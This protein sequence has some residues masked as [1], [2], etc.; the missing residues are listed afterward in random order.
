M[1]VWE[2][3]TASGPID[4]V[5][6]LPGSKSQTARALYLAAVSDAPTTIRGA[7]DAR[8]TRLFLGALEQM[9]AS[10]DTQGGALRVTPMGERPRPA[11]IDCGLAGTVMRFLPPLAA[12][13][14]GTTRFDGDA[15]ARARP[16]APLLGALEGMGARV[17]HEGAPGR[18]PF[19]IRG[20]LRTPL[21]AQ[22]AVDASA[23]SQFLSALLLVAPLIG[24]P[25]FVSAPGRVV[26]MPHV[27]MTV[28]ALARAGIDIEE[29]DEAGPVRTWHVFPGRP[30]PGDTDI[31][32]DLSNAGPFLAAAMVTGGRVRVPGWPRTTSQPGDAWRAILGH[33]GA[34][35]E[36][37]DDGLTVEGPGAGN[38]PGIDAD[39]SAVGE[40]T[41]ALAAI[42][43][44]A[45]SPSRL[46]GIAHLRGHETDRVAALAT[47]LNRLGGDAQDGGDC[48]AIAPAPLRPGTVETYE[49][50]RMAAFGAVLGLTTAGV[51]VRDI[52][53]TSKTLPGFARMW[54][55]A[56]AG[57]RE[58]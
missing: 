23:S 40:L 4:A 12:L 27:E 32:P 10:F 35:V 15:A 22:C 11:V 50:H 30:S 34:R 39:M 20:P 56:L 17:H 44:S 9:G 41:P 55:G 57:R 8:D 1:T 46:S 53:C 5:V 21:G 24:D 58:P 52:E 28:R 25:L 36:L 26:S 13:S 16:L 3:P 14:G 7:L 33:M 54:A 47:E 18:L 43:A 31:D 49:D 45:S 29:V 19:T 6:A 37:G 38:Y 48:L 2:A 42:C 51:G